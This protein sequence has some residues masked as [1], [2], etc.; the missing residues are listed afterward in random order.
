MDNS[1]DLELLTS[2][3]KIRNALMMNHGR[4]IVWA[5]LK[6]TCAINNGFDAIEIRQPVRRGSRLGDID[7][8]TVCAHTRRT[9]ADRND[10]MTPRRQASH[11][12]RPYQPGPSNNGYL[13]DGPLLPAVMP[14]IRARNPRTSSSK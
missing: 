12:G 11:D 4:R 5:V 13:H 10:R 1:A 9:S 2:R 3:E 6:Y 8:D 7:R 14:R